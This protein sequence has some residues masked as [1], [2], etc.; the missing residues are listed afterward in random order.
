MPLAIGTTSRHRAPA[1]LLAIIIVLRS[2]LFLPLFLP[3]S[4]PNTRRRGMVVMRQHTRVSTSGSRCSE[5]DLCA[6]LLKFMHL[7]FVGMHSDGSPVKAGIDILPIL[8]GCASGGTAISSW[9]SVGEWIFIRSLAA[10]YRGRLANS[11]LL[12]PGPKVKGAFGQI[13]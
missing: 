12:E 9:L 4:L 10:G 7:V 5:D 3:R 8:F 2:A 13:A 6:V 11:I 1:Y